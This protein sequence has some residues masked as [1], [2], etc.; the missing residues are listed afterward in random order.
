VV[1]GFFGCN[2]NNQVKNHSPSTATP[3]IDISAAI[4]FMSNLG[5]YNKFGFE[6]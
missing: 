4:A 2:P 5:V 3:A 6:Y 1:P